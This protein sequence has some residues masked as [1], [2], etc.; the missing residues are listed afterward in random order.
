MSYQIP[1]LAPEAHHEHSIEI[2]KS[3]F[4]AWLA[5]APTPDAMT[6]LLEQAHLAHPNACHHCT[7]FI[8]GAPNEQNAIGFS[9]DGEPGGTAGRPMYQ[10]LEGSGVGQIACVVIRYFGGIKLGTGGLAR[11]YSRAVLDALERLPTTTFTPR[12]PRR[13][14]VGFAHE[15]DVRHWLNGYDVP[16]DAS[17]YAADG[18]VLTAGWPQGGAQPPL[19]ELHARLKGALEVL[20]D[21]G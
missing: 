9:D 6:R 20:E 2:E 7:A 13:L 15:A 16:V 12:T 18:V 1:A 5:H 8:A 21:Q 10:V 4:I 19:E 11:A 14:K 17:D 3:R